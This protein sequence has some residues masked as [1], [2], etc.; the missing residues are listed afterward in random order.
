MFKPGDDPTTGLRYDA[1]DEGQIGIAKQRFIR[2]I[3]HAAAPARPSLDF[4][5]D[6]AGARGARFAAF[7]VPRRE[8]DRDSRLRA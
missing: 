8:R 4:Q 2:P 5:L 7:D 3:Q 6:H 1:G